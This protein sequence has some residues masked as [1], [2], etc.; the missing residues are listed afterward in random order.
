MLYGHP[1][2]PEA[3]F[4]ELVFRWFALL[5]QGQAA[6]AMALIDESNS[7][8]IKWEPEHLSSALRSYGGNSIL[9]V[10]TSPSSASGQQHASLTALADRSGYAYVHD[11]P[12]NG[13][14]SDLTAQFEFLKRPNGFAVVLHDI[15]VL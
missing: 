10:V 1:I 7:Y 5:A 6:E 4:R 12:L 14:W 2:N 3:A 15:H 9:P 8:G 11:L 13:Q